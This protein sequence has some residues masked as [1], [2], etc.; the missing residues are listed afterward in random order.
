MKSEKCRVNR[1]SGKVWRLLLLLFTFL[2]SPL[3]TSCQGG[4]DDGRRLGEVVVGTWERG[5]NEGDI[6]IEGDPSFK[7]DNITYDLFYFYGDGDYN[8]MVRSGSFLTVDTDG[9]MIYEGS[10]QCDNNNLKLDCVNSSGERRKIL[11][12]ILSF[13]DKEMQIR[14]VNEEYDV[15]ITVIIRKQSDSV[16]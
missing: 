14:Y 4:D 15:T 8:G 2:F 1:K 6:I 7:P 3:L 13:S 12:Q 16:K 11:A 5:W 10:Y 9:E